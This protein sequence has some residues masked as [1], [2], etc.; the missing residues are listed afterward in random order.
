MADGT[1]KPAFVGQA[2][3]L[4][5]PV[6]VLFAIG[7]NSLR[8]DK[9]QAHREAAERA[10]Q[11]ASSLAARGAAIFTGSKVDRSG[12]GY[13][14]QVNRTGE[15]LFPPPIAT[16]TPKPLL[17]S[18]LTR[19]QQEFWRKARELE[20][21]SDGT[22][23]AIPAYTSF[24][25]LTPPTRF[26]ANATY[27][28]GLLYSAQGNF[29][30]AVAA[31]T[32]LV[33]DQPD[34]VTESG[35]AFKPLAMIKLL[36]LQRRIPDIGRAVSLGS[37]YSN[38]I[39]H[40]TPL[41]RALLR[42]TDQ[43][44]RKSAGD[45]VLNR[46]AEI[47][48][49]HE[50]IRGLHAAAA[51]YSIAEVSVSKTSESMD[52]A[53]A[54]RIRAGSKESDLSARRAFWFTEPPSNARNK[55]NVVQVSHNWLAIPYQKGLADCWFACYPESEAVALVRAM[56]DQAEPVAGYLDA[57]INLAGKT[58]ATSHRQHR[59]AGNDQT[60][61]N[62]E[63]LGSAI[64]PEGRNGWIEARV[65]LTQPAVLYRHQRVRRFWFGGLIAT[66]AVA[67]LVGL[68]SS[69]RAFKRQQRLNELKSN[70]VSSVSHELRTPVASVRLLVE[71]LESG[72]ISGAAKQ[73]EYLHL[74]G[75]ECRRLSGLIDNI[76]DFSR[77]DDGRKQFEFSPTDVEALVSE[78]AKII[79]PYATERKVSLTT[80]AAGVP[81]SKPN[82]P[83]LDGLAVRQA[84]FNLLDNAIKHSTAGNTVTVGVDW[85][86]AGI[87]EKSCV[88]I[89]V[90]DHGAGIPAEEHEKIFERFYRRGSEL[91][92]E[93]QGIGIGLTIVK[94]IAEAHG[95]RVLVRSAVGQGS[96]FTM[97][98][99]LKRKEQSMA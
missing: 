89:A 43:L 4:L 9:I 15:L 52:Q 86:C 67:A 76:L 58:A 6:I 11:L 99:P 69:W 70:F 17:M 94:H 75:Q 20:A 66:C 90:E 14:F 98:L 32:K 56:M 93:T 29:S 5:V 38:L 12:T 82:T 45:S 36:E 92:R 26:A 61:R 33:E 7:L 65:Y 71:G 18:E 39:Y 81:P 13:V 2:L 85:T 84:L 28:L 47:W 22:A 59:S 21:L 30:E 77:I 73:K 87:G 34:A 97:E 1:K 48:S 88:S 37:V 16:L 80:T 40:P 55:T 72:R 19:E 83:I 44:A 74:M 27:S 63:L 35:M 3:L 24:V 51:L 23:E 10:Q 95:G 57:E 68:V 31:F 42:Q 49:E 41:S 46:C 50:R 64:R 54:S 60:E 91:N 25:E 78:T 79:E 62:E 8:Q 96:K 53:E